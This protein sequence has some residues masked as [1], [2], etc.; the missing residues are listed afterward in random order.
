MEQPGKYLAETKTALAPHLT[1]FG[2]NLS[3]LASTESG[4]FSGAMENE[5]YTRLL[6][7]LRGYRGG[8]Q[9]QLTS[10]Y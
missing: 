10:T 1:K 6:N 4:V 7:A 3:N 8:L 5:Q 2:G 9:Q